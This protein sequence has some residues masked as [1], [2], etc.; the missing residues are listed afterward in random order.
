MLLI[1]PK[2]NI[3]N[4]ISL[5]INKNL[6]QNDKNGDKFNKTINK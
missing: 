4:K 6:L 1:L 3:N 2:I 5:K